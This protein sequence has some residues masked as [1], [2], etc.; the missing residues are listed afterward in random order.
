MRPMTGPRRPTPTGTIGDLGEDEL[1]AA[2]LE[3]LPSGRQVLLGSRRRR[4]RGRRRGRPRGRDDRR[5]RRRACTSAGTGPRR[6]TSGDKAAA[7]NLADVAAMGARPTALLVG[8]AAPAGPAG[9]VGPRAGRRAGGRGGRAGAAVVGGD[10]VAGEQRGRRGH[11]AGHARR[12]RAG[13]PRGRA[14]R[15]RG[16]G[17]RPARLVGGRAGRAQPRVP[18][19]P[20]A[21]RR[22]P[23]AGAAVRGRTAAALAGATAMVDVSD[24]LLADLGTSPRRR[25]GASSSTSAA[26]DGRPQPLRDAA[27]ALGKDPL[28]WVLTGGEDHALGGDVPDA[29][30]SVP[31][32]WAVVGEVLAWAGSARAGGRY[33]RAVAGTHA[34]GHGGGAAGGRRTRGRAAGGTSAADAPVA[35]GRC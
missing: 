1:V 7:Q 10:V 33:R 19:A 35:R 20:G 22:A 5:A 6:R 25:R 23:A 26:L 13:D 12:P 11:G 29:A 32:G 28:E 15:R 24:G 18:L 34:P 8:L 4:R 17:G 2:I 16:G 3:R 9:G 27:A 21:G 30:K 31:K 14:A